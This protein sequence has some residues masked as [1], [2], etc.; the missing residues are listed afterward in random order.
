MLADSIAAVVYYVYFTVS[1]FEGSAS[2]AV[3]VSVPRD[4]N[5]DFAI[6]GG[7]LY[8]STR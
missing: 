5:G 6:D 2:G 4:K 3:K 1:D 7:E 8:D